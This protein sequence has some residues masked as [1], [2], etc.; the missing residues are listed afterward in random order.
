MQRDK[1][2][3]SRKFLGKTDAK[4]S[5]IAQSSKGKIEKIFCVYNYEVTDK[6]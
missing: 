2:L 6:L 5:W 3:L 1:I 4:I